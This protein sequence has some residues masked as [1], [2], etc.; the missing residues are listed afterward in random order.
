MKAGVKTTEFW[1]TIVASTLLFGLSLAGMFAPHWAPQL[2]MAATVIVQVASAL[3]A[4]A[5]GLGGSQL[6]KGYV[7]SRTAL[8]LGEEVAATVEKK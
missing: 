2:D 6:A 3:G 1:V 8:K 5:L 4:T 7:A